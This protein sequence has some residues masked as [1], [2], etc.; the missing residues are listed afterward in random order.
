[1]D[2]MIAAPPIEALRDW[3]PLIVTLVAALWTWWTSKQ[4]YKWQVEAKARADLMSLET[5]KLRNEYEARKEFVNDL[6][7]EC[8]KMRAECQIQR[9][10][11]QVL[12]ETINKRDETI[13]E[14]RLKIRT[15]EEKVSEL[16]REVQSLEATR[17]KM[18]QS[19]HG[20]NSTDR[21]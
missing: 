20:G 9:A 4:A 14:M 16:Q 5:E 13:S 7:E 2:V 12:R 11:N 21:S 10:E 15:L 18:E 17:A 19:N 8:Q 6:M 1:M 3:W